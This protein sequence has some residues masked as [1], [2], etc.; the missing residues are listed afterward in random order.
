LVEKKWA[1]DRVLKI[2]SAF[3]KNPLFKEEV[4]QK[5]IEKIEKMYREEF[6]N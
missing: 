5:Q 3:F 4:I 1:V 6:T 2:F